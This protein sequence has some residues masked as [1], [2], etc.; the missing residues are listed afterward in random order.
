MVE[1]IAC[2]CGVRE[3]SECGE[4]CSSCF[5]ALG[6]SIDHAVCKKNY[7]SKSKSSSFQF[8]S[9]RCESHFFYLD[10]TEAGCVEESEEFVSYET[11]Y[12]S[13]TI[14]QWS[15]S[16]LLQYVKKCF[17]AGQT[18]NT[19]ML[20]LSNL[21]LVYFNNYKESSSLNKLLSFLRKWLCSAFFPKPAN[22]CLLYTLV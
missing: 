15:F 18:A 13:K 21:E 2:S 14:P 5:L 6:L 3:G 8:D 17:I 20:P 7:V 1:V 9:V 10:V 11:R 4:K 19:N 22:S 12:Q 16:C